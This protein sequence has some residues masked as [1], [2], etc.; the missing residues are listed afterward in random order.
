[1]GQMLLVLAHNK[2]FARIEGLSDYAGSGANQDW[3]GRI[4]FEVQNNAGS[5]DEHSQLPTTGVR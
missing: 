1:M 4:D 3:R 2:E 5:F